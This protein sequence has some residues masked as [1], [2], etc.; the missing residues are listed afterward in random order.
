[1]STIQ[2]TRN[3]QPEP[4]TI[5]VESRPVKEGEKLSNKGNLQYIQGITADDLR[6]LS[7]MLLQ[8]EDE[9]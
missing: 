4:A 2:I 7:W 5:L 8:R 3:W 9:I 6:G 1:M